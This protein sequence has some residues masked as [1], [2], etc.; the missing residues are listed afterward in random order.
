MDG[1]ID[2]MDMN[3][4]KLWEMVEDKGVWRVTVHGVTES[5]TTGQLNKNEHHTRQSS[6]GFVSNQKSPTSRKEENST[7]LGIKS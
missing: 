1:I 3:L 2:S 7:L 6:R 4:S 5:D